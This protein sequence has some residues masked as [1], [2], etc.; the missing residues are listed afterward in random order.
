MA[1]SKPILV[2]L[3]PKD[4]HLEFDFRDDIKALASWPTQK[5][6]DL[7]FEN[8]TGLRFLVSKKRIN[9]MPVIIQEHIYNSP[10]IVCMFDNDDSTLPFHCLDCAE[11]W[12]TWFDDKQADWGLRFHGQWYREYV[13]SFGEEGP[14][15]H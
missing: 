3:T 10:M 11:Q 2:I 15:F 12:M 5:L 14:V 4:D 7:E 8:G 1:A 13:A 6:H 9:S